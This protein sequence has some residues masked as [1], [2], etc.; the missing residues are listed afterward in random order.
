MGVSTVATCFYPNVRML[1]MGVVP[2][3][4]W[5]LTAGY[6]IYDGYFLNDAGATIGHAGHLGGAAFGAL[7][8]LLRLRML[9]IPPPFRLVKK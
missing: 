4:L 3:P 7:Y 9:K 8:Y 1:L 2:M 5:A 6:I